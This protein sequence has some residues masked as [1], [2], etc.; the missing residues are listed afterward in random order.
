MFEGL[1][2]VISLTGRENSHILLSALFCLLPHLFYSFTIVRD[3]RYDIVIQ[4]LN[5]A[6]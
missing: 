3:M 6:C 2:Q 5:D 1:R 4:V